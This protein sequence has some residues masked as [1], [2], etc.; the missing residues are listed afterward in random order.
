MRKLKFIDL[1]AGL[2]G[3][4]EPNKLFFATTHRNNMNNLYI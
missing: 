3:I 2:G 1:F 4:A